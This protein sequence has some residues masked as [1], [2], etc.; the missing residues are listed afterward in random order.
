M[1]LRDGWSSPSTVDNQEE[2]ETP[3]L[4]N[5]AEK[6][7]GWFLGKVCIW[8]YISF[9]RFSQ[10]EYFYGLWFGLGLDFLWEQD[11]VIVKL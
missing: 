5:P 3:L 10:K 4:Q 9:W 6:W 2:E 1:A 7:T 8:D 11:S